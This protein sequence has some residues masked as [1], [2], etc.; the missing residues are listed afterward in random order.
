MRTP[1]L[2]QAMWKN[3]NYGLYLC[4]ELWNDFISD[5]DYTKCMDIS[6]TKCMDI[7]KLET[8]LKY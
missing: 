8:V 2:E 1:R 3:T 6:Y 7:S 4:N 5:Y